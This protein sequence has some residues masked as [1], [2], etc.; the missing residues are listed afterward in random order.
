MPLPP[1][2]NLLTVHKHRVEN[3]P[4]VRV[5]QNVPDRQRNRRTKQLQHVNQHHL[6]LTAVR[7]LETAARHRLQQNADGRA[8]V[9]RLLRDNARLEK[10]VQ[11]RQHGLHD[12][13]RY[14]RTLQ[15][16][17][18]GVEQHRRVDLVHFYASTSHG[19]D[20]IGLLRVATVLLRM[21]E[22]NPTS[23]MASCPQRLFCRRRNK[24]VRISPTIIFFADMRW[25]HEEWNYEVRKTG[26]EKE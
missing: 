6:V 22:T 23:T 10:G 14:G 17:N 8:N 11:C 20:Q 12:G 25:N 13:S 7:R 1:R 18:E 3:A 4:N 5:A 2:N 15:H 16:H 21:G 19:F 24:I 9:H 26:C